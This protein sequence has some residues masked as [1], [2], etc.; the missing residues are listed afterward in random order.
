MSK[1]N[2]N[3]P[4]TAWRERQA[5]LSLVG[6][7]CL[8][9]KAVTFPPRN[10]CSNP[11]CTEKTRL[12]EF[13]LSGKGEIIS[14]TTISNPK[15]APEGFDEDFV[16]YHLVLVKLYEG[17]ILFTRFTDFDPKQ[18]IQ[19]GMKVELITRIWKKNGRK[20]PIEYGYAVRSI[21]IPKIL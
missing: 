12:K 19:E 20:G 17:P 7:L 13:K 14:Y 2:T 3:I 10:I 15:Y 16:P 9:C 21:F 8:S 1:E 4:Y 6:K 18:K 5:R 11:D